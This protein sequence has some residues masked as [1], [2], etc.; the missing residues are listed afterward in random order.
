MTRLKWDDKL[1]KLTTRLLEE[2]YSSIIMGYLT[3]SEKTLEEYIKNLPIK[4]QR[5]LI[6]IDN[7][8]TKNKKGDD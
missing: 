4:R 5:R 3:A 1:D 8:L 7:I 6:E 2:E